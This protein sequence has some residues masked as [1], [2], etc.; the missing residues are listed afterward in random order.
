[1]I[2][3]YIYS[4]GWHMKSVVC[5]RQHVS[6]CILSGGMDFPTAWCSARLPCHRP[7]A[8]KIWFPGPVSSAA[9][10]NRIMEKE[11]SSGQGRFFPCFLYLSITCLRFPYFFCMRIRATNVGNDRISDAF[12]FCMYKSYPRWITCTPTRIYRPDAEHTTTLRASQTRVLVAGFGDPHHHRP[13][14]LPTA[15]YQLHHWLGARMF[16]SLSE[17]AERWRAECLCLPVRVA[18]SE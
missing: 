12:I 14:G 16:R 9:G 11:T 8:A 15:Q 7:G 3:L 2:I 17:S 13:S 1:M 6:N 4:T 10:F 18:T 5:E